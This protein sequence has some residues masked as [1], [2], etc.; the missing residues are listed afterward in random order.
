MLAVKM[1]LIGI[2]M[3]PA[4][5]M[6]VRAA[7]DVRRDLVR[8]KRNARGQEPVRRRLRAVK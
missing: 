1:V 7:A 4:A 3:I 6:M 5:F 8:Q 2:V